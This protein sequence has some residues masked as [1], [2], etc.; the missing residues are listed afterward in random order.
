MNVRIKPGLLK[1]DLIVPP[2]K[3]LS[4][5]A[6]IA[7]GLSKGKSVISNILFSKDILATISAFEA[8]GAKVLREDDSLIIEGKG[9]VERINNIIDSNESGSTVRFMI[10]IAL[11]NDEPI[12]FVGKNNL[13]NRPLDTFLEIFNEQNIKYEKEENTYLPLKVYGGIKPGIFKIKG[14]ISSQFITGLLYALPL[15]KEDSKIIITTEL[16][17]KGYIDLT[18]DMLKLFGIEIINNNYK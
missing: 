3:S 7:A 6:I 5:R 17:S 14:D 15:L 2:S 13:V 9:Y 11:T 18:I 4:H 8:I 12:T 10:P 1:G 16:E